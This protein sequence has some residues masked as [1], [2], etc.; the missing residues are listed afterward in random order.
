MARP[1]HENPTPGE[2]AVL[3]ILWERGPCNGRQMMEWLNE[4]GKKRAYTSVTSLLNVM[5]DK[6][7]VER[8]PEGRAFLYEAKA[9]RENTQ[10]SLL[11]DL[12]ERL[13]ADSAE[14]MVTAL[15]EYRGLT[16]DEAQ[17]IREMIEQADTKPKRNSRKEKR[18]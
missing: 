2:L 1:K 8:T 18:S 16:S 17:R 12:V 13:F 5:T 15:I 4:D 10:R 14:E 3:Q 7:L 11:K 9:K 6:G